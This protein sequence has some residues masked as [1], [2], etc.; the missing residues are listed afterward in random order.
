MQKQYD[1]EMPRNFGSLAHWLPLLVLKDLQSMRM[2]PC[3]Q[4]AGV[5]FETNLAFRFPSRSL[6]VPY[7]ESQVPP[8]DLLQFVQRSFQRSLTVVEAPFNVHTYSPLQRGIYSP[9]EGALPR[10]YLGRSSQCL[11]RSLAVTC[12]EL[13]SVLFK[14]A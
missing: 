8:S 4:D 10:S 7:K 6:S 1:A 14:E 9:L 5:P 13:L 12:Q 11:C 2:G 3:L